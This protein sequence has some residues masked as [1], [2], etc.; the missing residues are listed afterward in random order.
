MYSFSVINSYSI[1]KKRSVIILNY[2]FLCS[3]IKYETIF[4]K[5]AKTITT[6]KR[7]EKKKKQLQA[8]FNS[9]R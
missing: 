4:D 7:R 8:H 5:K 2:L 9:G 1:G 6:W 3:A